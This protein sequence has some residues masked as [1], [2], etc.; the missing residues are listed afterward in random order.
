MQQ[1]VLEVSEDT[2]VPDDLTGE[3]LMDALGILRKLLGR[4]DSSGPSEW[5][6]WDGALSRAQALAASLE[7]RVVNLG[8]QLDALEGQ[9]SAMLRVAHDLKGQLHVISDSRP[10]L[11]GPSGGAWERRYRGASQWET[12]MLEAAV[13][14]DSLGANATTRALKAS[15]EGVVPEAVVQKE[16]NVPKVRGWSEGHQDYIKWYAEKKGAPTRK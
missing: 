5:A 4:R 13:A 8:A 15:L 7:T 16:Y 12:R 6:R 3:D 10:W 11:P 9:R 14:L 2:A 1:I